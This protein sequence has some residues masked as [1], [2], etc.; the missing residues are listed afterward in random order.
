MKGS[1]SVSKS[2]RVSVGAKG[3]SS[4]LRLATRAFEVSVGALASSRRSKNRRGRVTKRKEVNFENERRA[5]GHAVVHWPRQA[6]RKGGALDW[7]IPWTSWCDARVA[8]RR[9]ESCTEMRGA[10]E[11][12]VPDSEYA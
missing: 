4:I 12:R 11:L 9:C 5:A 7:A 1:S 6:S 8:V 2:R 10:G 3:G